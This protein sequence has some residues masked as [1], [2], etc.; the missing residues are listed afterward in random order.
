[1][2]VIAGTLRCQLA[3]ELTTRFLADR[4]FNGDAAM[5]KFGLMFG[6][7]FFYAFTLPPQVEAGV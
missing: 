5:A 6:A 2:L 1:M 4:L 3:I 7:V